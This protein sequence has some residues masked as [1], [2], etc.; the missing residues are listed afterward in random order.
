MK[1]SS[2]KDLSDISS[3][4][5]LQKK[6]EIEFLFLKDAQQMA[7]NMAKDKNCYLQQKK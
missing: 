4:F 5:L 1:L 6:S 2:R 7:A 3:L